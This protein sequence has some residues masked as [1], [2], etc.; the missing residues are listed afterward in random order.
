MSRSLSKPKN[1]RRRQLPSAGIK[2]KIKSKP[3]ALTRCR[4]FCVRSDSGSI[5]L[6]PPRGF[7][8]ATRLRI[9]EGG[10]VDRYKDGRLSTLP[11]FLADTVRISENN[12]VCV[13]FCKIRHLCRAENSRLATLTLHTSFSV[14][15]LFAIFSAAQTGLFSLRAYRSEVIGFTSIAS[16]TGLFSLLCNLVRPCP[17]TVFPSKIAL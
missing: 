3:S 8:E 1:S 6:R 13:F 2:T 5:S 4:G 14:V 7:R 12:V 17:P 15:C 16:Q 9:G 10:I 11:V